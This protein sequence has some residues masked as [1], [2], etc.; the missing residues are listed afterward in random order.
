M[1]KLDVSI[2]RELTQAHK[3][4]PARPGIGPTTREISRK[5]KIPRATVQYRIRKMYGTGVIKGSSILL[6]PRLLGMEYGAY[7]VD[8]SRKL[9][10]SA[11]V[12]S[13][14]LIEG[15]L[16][17]HDFI[18]ALVWVG[19]VYQNEES[20]ASKLER[21]KEIAGAQGR[22][23]RIPYP[24]PR[25]SVARSEATL[26]LRLLKGGFG[27]YRGLA[28]ELCV[29]VR[30]L[31][32]TISKLVEQGAIFSL[33]KVDYQSMTHCIP[34]DLHVLF[35]D[36]ETARTSDARILPLVAD[37]L[38]FA[39]LWD[40]LGMCSLILPNIRSM[41]RIVS[42]VE[43]V[44]GVSSARIDIV[45]EHIDQTKMLAPSLERWLRT[46]SGSKLAPL[47]KSRRKSHH[48]GRVAFGQPD[49]PQA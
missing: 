6:N 39:A 16:F 48:I 34:A 38:V 17:L 49:R 13:L 33:P 18:D 19:F 5:L 40:T 31:Q 32:R 12:E 3:L 20:L 2:L 44:E 28:S 22:F 47:T 41:S 43:R 29:S 4:L 30:T 37:Y 23:S 25:G 27:S 1:D 7:V 14:R 42:S 8:V 36:S 26:I 21:I 15:T 9:D 46:T 35:S 24:E 11:V 45:R 10:K